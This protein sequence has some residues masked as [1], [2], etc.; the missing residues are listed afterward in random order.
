MGVSSQFPSSPVPFPGRPVSR[1][2]PA[3]DAASAEPRLAFRAAL[4][5][6]KGSRLAAIRLAQGAAPNDARIR[7]SGSAGGDHRASRSSGCGCGLNRAGP[8]WLAPRLDAFRNHGIE[9]VLALRA[10]ACTSIL[11]TDPKAAILKLLELGLLAIE[12]G[13][14]LA[15]AEDWEEAVAH[16]IDVR[17]ATRAS[18]DLARAPDRTA[19]PRPAEGRWADQPGA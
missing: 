7:P 15:A 17:V 19:G 2:A 14:G 12:P 11:G 18:G 16:P 1:A 8:R 4:G 9:V 6:Y 10:L 3:P 13:A 5:R